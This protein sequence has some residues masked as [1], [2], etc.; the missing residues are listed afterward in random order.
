MNYYICQR[1]DIGTLSARLSVH[2]KPMIDLPIP[3]AA[4]AVAVV[5]C[6]AYL[7]LSLSQPPIPRRVVSSS[8]CSCCSFLLPSL[9]HPLSVFSQQHGGVEGY[10]ELTPPW[11]ILEYLGHGIEMLLTL[12]KS[13]LFHHFCIVLLNVFNLALA[14]FLQSSLHLIGR[15]PILTWNSPAADRQIR[16]AALAAG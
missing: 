16:A 4:A 5:C 12:F 14:L 2:P 10:D 6:D 8:L 3:A 11:T 1:I 7:Y 9:S 13:F 15:A